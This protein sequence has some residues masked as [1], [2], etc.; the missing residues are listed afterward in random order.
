MNN[1]GQVGG[2]PKKRRGNWKDLFKQNITITMLII[3]FAVGVCSSLTAS[4]LYNRWQGLEA[5]SSLEIPE[6]PGV[7]PVAYPE[8]KESCIPH[9]SAAHLLDSLRLS[10][11]IER[12]LDEAFQ[13]VALGKCLQL[14][15]WVTLVKALPEKVGNH[16]RIHLEEEGSRVPIEG[17]SQQDLSGWIPGTTVWVQGRISDL[18]LNTLVLDRI[19]LSRE[20][21]LAPEEM[22]QRL[23]SPRADFWTDWKHFKEAC[24]GLSRS[25]AISVLVAAFS[26]LSFLA[27]LGIFGYRWSKR[28]EL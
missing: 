5:I 20:R 16:W 12:S 28:Q 15:G 17:R 13:Q 24:P 19:Q 8:G 10:A 27:L 6:A 3:T 4:Y 25:L 18:A 21:P 23:D 1:S 2:K 14:P 9:E 7:E 22:R 11:S 26:N